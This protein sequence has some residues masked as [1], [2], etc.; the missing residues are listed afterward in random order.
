MSIAGRKLRRRARFGIALLTA[1]FLVG[2][3]PAKSHPVT[4]NGGNKP[5]VSR[6]TKADKNR[7][8]LRGWQTLDTEKDGSVQIRYNIPGPFSRVWTW[9][10][11]STFKRPIHVDYRVET[12]TRS[13]FPL[14]LQRTAYIPARGKTDRLG[15]PSDLEP[16]V[17]V[18][19]VR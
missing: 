7:G 6:N 19:Q 3:G 18:E 10:F 12:I 13:G 11:R 16:T 9:R 4:Y 5:A 8:G 17:S 15:V 14:I 2:I 1:A